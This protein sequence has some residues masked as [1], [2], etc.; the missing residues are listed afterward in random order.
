[1]GEFDME[2]VGI[3]KFKENMGHY[4]ELLKS[5]QDIIL[6]DRKKQ[7]ARITPAGIPATEEAI[8]QMV[9]DGKANWGGGRP[10]ALQ[11]RVKVEGK[12]VADAVV[13]GRR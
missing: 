4:V 2:S 12:G 7:I 3:R 9:M 8:R 5:G 6:T 10:Q 1:M 13:E 11:G